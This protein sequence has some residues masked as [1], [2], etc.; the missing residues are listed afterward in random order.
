[1]DKRVFLLPKLLPRDRQICNVVDALEELPISEGWRVE[2]REHSA[3]RSELQNNTLWWIYGKI[4]KL[5][6][7][8]MEGWTKDDL[9]EHFLIEHFGY[10][11]SVIFGKR[12]MKPL[13]RSSKLSKSEFAKLVDFI[14]NYMANQGVILPQPNPD[15]AEHREEEAA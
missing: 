4:L 14:Y 2:I 8:T 13:R 12:R 9:H 15:Y 7:V 5:G 3:T 10:R 1:M 6:G 11:I